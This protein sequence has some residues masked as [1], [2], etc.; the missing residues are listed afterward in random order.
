MSNLG[1]GGIL[2]AGAE[3]RFSAHVRA[4]AGYAG[5]LVVRLEDGEGR[6]L[7]EAAWRNRPTGSS[8]AP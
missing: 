8:G 2:T 4:A 6:V 5:R 1:Y 3:Y 7:A